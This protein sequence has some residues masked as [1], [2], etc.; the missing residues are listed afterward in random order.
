MPIFARI[1][2]V[3]QLLSIDKHSTMDGKIK[4]KLQNRLVSRTLEDTPQLAL[5]NYLDTEIDDYASE[6]PCRLEAGHVAKVM[7]FIVVR[8]LSNLYSRSTT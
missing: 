5:L 3:T 4:K 1:L 7:L 6:N 8:L 2:T